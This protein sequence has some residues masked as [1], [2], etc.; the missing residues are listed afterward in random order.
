MAGA[1]EGLALIEV[2]LERHPRKEIW[3]EIFCIGH[4]GKESQ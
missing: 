1:A 2:R 3:I 4:R